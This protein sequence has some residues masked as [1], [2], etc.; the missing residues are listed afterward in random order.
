M[1]IQTRARFGRVDMKHAWCQHRR[2]RF[3]HA[4]Y[5]ARQMITWAC[6]FA[7]VTLDDQANGACQMVA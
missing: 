2:A 6:A 7:H 5:G 4:R 3:G 1:S